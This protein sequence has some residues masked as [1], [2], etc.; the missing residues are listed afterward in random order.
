MISQRDALPIYFRLEGVLTV[1]DAKRHIPHAF[2]MPDDATRLD[3]HFVCEPAAA[4]GLDNMLTL[5][6]FDAQGW[7]GARHRGGNRHDVWIEANA[8]TPGYLPGPLPPGAWIVQIDAH[9]ILP[10]APLHYT[11]DIEIR[12]EISSGAPGGVTPDIGQAASGQVVRH[13]PG[14]FR[15]DL[16]SHTDHSDAGD[17][18]VTQLIQAAHA[19]DL[20]FLFLTDHNTISPLAQ[21]DALSSP[22]LLVAGGVEL[23]TFW[24]HALVL[25]ARRWIDWRFR[26]GDNVIN[27]LAE[28]A[29]AN[30]HLFIMAHPASGGDPY[31][32]GC[33][34]RFGEMMPGAARIIE[35]W[36]GVWAGDSNNELALALYYDWLNQGHRLVATAGSDTHSTADYAAG[37]GFNVIYAEELSEAALLRAIAAGHL[38]LSSGPRLTL[39]AQ[40]QDGAVRRM[41]DIVTQPATVH[42]R[43]Q[44]CPEGAVLR[45]LANGQLLHQQAVEVEGSFLYTLTP[46][47][48]NW[49]AAEVR[50]QAGAL[51]AITNPIFFDEGA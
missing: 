46:V 22:D 9:R 41:G 28:E 40:E 16:H 1:R 45:V 33:A 29:Y 21:V 10:G 24:G 20:D 27:R 43:W 48:A 25:G 19:V 17:R 44:A 8:A 6:L 37:P 34:W 32:T 30:G 42:V 12:T 11:L 49:L 38:Y 14:W 26:P 5:S 35:I 15:G 50:D 2:V 18:T 39:E 4:Q 13:A 7:R 23:T 36:N 47:D 3:I 51:L 31:C